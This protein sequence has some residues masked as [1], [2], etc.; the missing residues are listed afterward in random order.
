M[1]YKIDEMLLDLKMATDNAVCSSTTQACA[2]LPSPLLAALP[3]D[4]Y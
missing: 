3:A 4:E 1:Y 2:F